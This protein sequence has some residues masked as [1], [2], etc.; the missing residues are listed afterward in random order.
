MV[1]SS[2]REI[3][4]LKGEIRFENLIIGGVIHH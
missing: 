1:N 3:D 2:G 4:L